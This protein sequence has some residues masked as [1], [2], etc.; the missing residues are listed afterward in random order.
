MMGRT[1]PGQLLGLRRPSK[2]G[3]LGLQD[4]LTWE[5]IVG[6][7]RK[8][9]RGMATDASTKAHWEASPPRWEFGLAG[10]LVPE[11]WLLNLLFFQSPPAH[12]RPHRAGVETLCLCVH[13]NGFSTGDES[14]PISTNTLT[15]GAVGCS[16]EHIIPPCSILSETR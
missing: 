3:T 1:P 7:C 16:A 4:S 6:K 14:C 9:A 8:T 11:L 13:W 5:G 2:H 12:R 15:V 10:L